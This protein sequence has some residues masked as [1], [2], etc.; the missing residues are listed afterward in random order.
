MSSH[1]AST[2]LA[3][4]VDPYPAGLEVVATLGAIATVLLAPFV[5]LLAWL[6]GHRR[7]GLAGWSAWLLAMFFSFFPNHR[8][9]NEVEGSSSWLVENWFLFQFVAYLLAFVGLAVS[10]VAAM[11]LARPDSW[12]AQRRYSAERFQRSLA[13]YRDP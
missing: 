10:I 8:L 13:T 4:D 6:K 9:E 5:G 12:W 1:P 7:S 3:S 2:V 11:R